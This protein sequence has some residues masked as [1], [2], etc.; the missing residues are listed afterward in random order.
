MTWIKL[1]DTI[2]D[3]PKVIG[4]SGDAFKMYIAGLCYSSRFLTD[5]YLNPLIVKKIGS[6]K[7]AKELVSSGLWIEKDEGFQV[8]DYLKHQSSKAQVEREK[9]LN[10]QRVAK[11]NAKVNGINNSDL[12]HPDNR[13]QIQST[14]NREQIEIK[15]NYIHEAEFE[16]A[17]PR[18]GSAK[19]AVERISSKLEEARANGINAWNL[20]K[21]VEAEWDTLHDSNDIGGAIALTAWYV[22]ELQ[23]RKLTSPEIARIGQMTKRFGRISLLAIDEAAAKDLNDLPSYAFRIAQNMYAQ[24]KARE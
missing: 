5:G 4:L 15:D 18:V 19:L 23:S 10:R 9:E 11:H 21:L 12:M 2:I 24:R 1:D 17:L 6:K 3:N 16:I 14:D 8:H 20:S 7:C 13:V 22:S